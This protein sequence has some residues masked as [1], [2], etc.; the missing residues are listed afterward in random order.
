MLAAGMF[1]LFVKHR[2]W[3]CFFLTLPIYVLTFTTYQSFIPFTLCTYL[4]IFLSLIFKEETEPEV[5]QRSII[6]SIIHFLIVLIITQ[7]IDKICFSSS[8]YLS[9][10]IIWTSESSFK[11]SLLSVADSCLRMLTG[12]GIFYTALLL[13]AILMCAASFWFYRKRPAYQLILG[14][15]AAIGITVT[16]FALT[17]LMG[18]N[19]AIRSQFTYSLAAVFLLFFSM[20]S[21][22][23]F[24]PYTHG[25][26]A[27]TKQLTFERL[28]MTTVLLVITV[29]QIGTVRYIWKAHSY[30]ADYDRETATDIIMA[31]YDSFVVDGQAGTIFWG[32]LQPKTPYDAALEGSPSYLFTSVFNLEH[33]MEPYCFYSTNRILGYMESMGH[34]FTYPTQRTHTISRYIM[35]RETL[36]SYPNESCSF[37]DLEAFTF[38]LGNCP[39]YY[40]R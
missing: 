15:L 36:A 21:F 9:D 7:V 39:E 17:L 33:D 10:Q 24:L 8:G 19:T 31:M 34:T 26:L 23:E 27:G 25:K 29:T 38:N 2:R 14:I 4:V 1:Y 18:S 22:L 13:F 3:S 28:I 40:Y 37:P 6:G 35:D 11:D 16:P 5:I 20:Q 30:V 12:Q 32:Y